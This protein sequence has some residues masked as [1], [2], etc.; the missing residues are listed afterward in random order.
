MALF[1]VLVQKINRYVNVIVYFYMDLFVCPHEH[2]LYT[3][4]RTA[5]QQC[6]LRNICKAHTIGHKQ[7]RTSMDQRTS[8]KL[9]HVVATNTTNGMMTEN[10]LSVKQKL[11]T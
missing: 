5:T 1:Y 4:L 3:N 6:I 9:S 10:L 7:I 11:Q 2:A 8:L